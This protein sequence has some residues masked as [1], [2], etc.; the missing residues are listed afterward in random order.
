M[1]AGLILALLS[2]PSLMVH[3]QVH[4]RQSALILFFACR[5]ISQQCYQAKE[6]YCWGNAEGRRNTAGEHTLS[7]LLSQIY[8]TENKSHRVRKHRTWEQ[9]SNPGFKDSSYL[10]CTTRGKKCISN[11]ES[12]C[13]TQVLTCWVLLQLRYRVMPHLCSAFEYSYQKTEDG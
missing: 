10:L 7:S 12:S 5:A 11:P 3:A 9:E 2:Q 8:S 6:S 13:Q 4:G 1:E